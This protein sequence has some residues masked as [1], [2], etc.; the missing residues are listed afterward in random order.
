MCLCIGSVADDVDRAS[1]DVS[2]PD[3][4]TYGVVRV[5]CAPLDVWLSCTPSEAG[6]TECD[7]SGSE[8]PPPLSPLLGKS[9]RILAILEIAASLSGGVR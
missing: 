6:R 9:Y 5:R 3:P 8:L 2:S 4:P 7:K 1:G